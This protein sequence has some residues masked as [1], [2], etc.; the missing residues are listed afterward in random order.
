MGLSPAS[1]AGQDKRQGDAGQKDGGGRG[2]PKVGGSVLELGVDRL[3][4]PSRHG[5]D[6]QRKPHDDRGQHRA[7]PMERQLLQPDCVLRH[8]PRARSRPNA[9]SSRFSPSPQAANQRRCT[10]AA[11]QQRLA[12]KLTSRQAQKPRHP[13][14]QGGYYQQC[15]TGHPKATGA[16]RPIAGGAST[17]ISGRGSKR[18]SAGKD[19]TCPPPT[20]RCAIER[21][22]PLSVKAAGRVVIGAE[23]YP[24]DVFIRHA[25]LRLLPWR[26]CG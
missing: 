7:G 5:P 8:G 19:R 3:Y 16:A 23:V 1:T 15:P 12:Q 11:V 14:R 18:R 2:H 6:H 25:D 4:S 17:V 10:G 9:I 24:L 20:R 26:R 13:K 21:A 22:A